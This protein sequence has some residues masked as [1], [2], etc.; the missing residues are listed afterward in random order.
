MQFLATGFLVKADLFKENGGWIHHLLT[1]DIEF[2]VSQ[3]L[4]GDKIG[5][6]RNAELNAVNSQLRFNNHGT[7]DYGGQK[8]FIK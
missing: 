5:Y 8:V 7:N 3:I 4:Q 6:S 2:S 1:E